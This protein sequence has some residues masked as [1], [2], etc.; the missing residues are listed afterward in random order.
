MIAHIEIFF[1]LNYYSLSWWFVVC[2]I[3]KQ[4]EAEICIAA[5]EACAYALKDLVSVFSPL[6]LDLVADNDNS[7]PLETDDKALLDVFASTFIHNINYIIDG[8]NLART[9]RAILMNCKVILLFFSPNKF[10]LLHFVISSSI[11]DKHSVFF[12]CNV[13]DLISVIGKRMRH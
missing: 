5:Y 11:L 13:N 9:R 8:G 1:I 6:A 12:L 7:F 4:V 3:V 2:V 10:G